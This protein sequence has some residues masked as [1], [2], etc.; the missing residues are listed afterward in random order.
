MGVVR[1]WNI[2]QGSCGCAI[3]GGVQG[4]IGWGSEQPAL[5]ED[6]SAHGRELKL[7]DL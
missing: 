7:H 6:V 4:H 5:V 2:A 1:I 3:P